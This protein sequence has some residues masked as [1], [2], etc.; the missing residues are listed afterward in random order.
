MNSIRFLLK[1]SA[2]INV[3]NRA[4]ETPLILAWKSF[5]SEVVRL[6][7]SADADPSLCDS[8]GFITLIYAGKCRP[9]K[10]IFLEKIPLLQPRTRQE[11][12]SKFEN[13]VKQLLSTDI[14]H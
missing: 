7:F 1:Y 13:T 8:H 5:N 12:R 2:D 3:Q 11:Q 14:R 4:G 10:D 9:I 6:L